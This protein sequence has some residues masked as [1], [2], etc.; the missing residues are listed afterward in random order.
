M[1]LYSTDWTGVKIVEKV[2]YGVC[3]EIT[4]KWKGQKYT[5]VSVYRPCNNDSEGSLR[6]SVDYEMKGALENTLWGAVKD[7]GIGTTKIIG[8]ILI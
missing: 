7:G 5:I 1:I 2:K 6:V 4:G 8:G 3:T